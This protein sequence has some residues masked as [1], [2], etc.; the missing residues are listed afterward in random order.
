MYAKV[1][2]Q[3]DAHETD[4]S[5]V[6]ASGAPSVSDILAAPKDKNKRAGWKGGNAKT[7]GSPCCCVGCGSKCL[8]HPIAS[9][10]KLLIFNGDCRCKQVGHY[11]LALLA[12]ARYRTA[13]CDDESEQFTS[14]RLWF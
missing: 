3:G 4:L 12:V 13:M 9:E 8:R 6:K 10:C 11:L 7:P 5:I 1:A 2:A 14:S